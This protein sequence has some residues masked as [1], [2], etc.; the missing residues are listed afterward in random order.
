MQKEYCLFCDKD[1]KE[2]HRVIIEN[3]LFYSRWDNF[4]V[5]DGHAEIV[6]KKHIVSFFDLSREEV[7]QMYELIVKTKKIIFEK[8]S[9]DSCNIGLNDGR[10]AGRTIDHLHIH[11]IPRYVGD[12]ENPRG[13]IRNVI[14]GK[15]NY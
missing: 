8:Y 13:G 15:G 9:P 14:P 3:D 12:V 6:P 4:P 7:L 5:S 2:K 11:I 10:A 1:N